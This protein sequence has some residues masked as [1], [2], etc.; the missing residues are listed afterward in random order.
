MQLEAESHA[1][2][3]Q[4]CPG[5]DTFN[6]NQGYLVTRVTFV[7]D[8]E[9]GIE[10]HQ[11]DEYRLA[12]YSLRPARSSDSRQAYF[13]GKLDVVCRSSLPVDMGYRGRAG[14]RTCN[15]RGIAA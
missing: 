3:R 7:T 9:I 14:Y 6:R 4:S 10:S 2:R 8:I 5:E 15:S 11:A 12:E 13:H 1:D